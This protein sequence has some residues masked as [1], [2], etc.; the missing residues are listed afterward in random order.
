[1]LV[2]APCLR[3]RPRLC[4]INLLRC[5]RPRSVNNL[6][7]LPG[8]LAFNAASADLRGSAGAPPCLLPSFPTVPS[9]TAPTL[10]TST[11]PSSS[12]QQLPQ[13]FVPVLCPFDPFH[14]FGNLSHPHPCFRLAPTFP[15]L[16]PANY[17]TPTSSRLPYHLYSHPLL[18]S[19][20]DTFPVPRPL[21]LLPSV[22]LLCTEY[23]I[24][25]HGVMNSVIPLTRG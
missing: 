12:P 19:A 15:A 2:G 25:L 5:W 1:M 6:A 4:G 22:T 20:S 11:S 7:I 21:L 8:A 13:R 18:S 16:Q 10:P 24:T 17:A 9:S 3:V 14:L 23:M